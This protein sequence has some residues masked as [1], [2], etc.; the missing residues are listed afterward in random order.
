[1]FEAAYNGG[2]LILKIGD[3]GLGRHSSQPAR[4]DFSPVVQTQP[5]R[6]PEVLLKLP[7]YAEADIW[8]AGIVI[9]EMVQGCGK[10]FLDTLH[11]S[12]SSLISEWHKLVICI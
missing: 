8:S 3:F 10:F 7:Y 12:D 1:M 4:A 6:S 9:G 2:F 11:N 5:Y